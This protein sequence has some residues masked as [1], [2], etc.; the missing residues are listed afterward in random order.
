MPVLFALSTLATILII[1][2]VVVVLLLLFGVGVYNTLVTLRNRYQNAFSQIDVQ[3]KRRYDLIPNLVETAKGYMRHERETLEAVINARNSALTASQR[4]AVSPGDAAAMGGL[5][6]AES[7]LSG[8]LGRLFALAEAYPDLKANQNMLSLQE[9]L[10]STENK[11]AFARQ[12]FND[13]VTSYNTG[14]QKFPNN[15]VA[16]MTGFAP[17]QL[18]EAESP[19]EREA[20]RVA[21]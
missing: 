10:T 14:I 13:A 15:L 7:Q 2:C 4:V 3:L 6:L 16:D 21:F 1:P 8:A 18:F 20:P 17:A 11:V 5:N 9:E 12:S 19:K